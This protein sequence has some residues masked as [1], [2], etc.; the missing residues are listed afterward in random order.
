MKDF[1][2]DLDGEL[3]LLDEP[4]LGD[5]VGQAVRQGRRVRRRRAAGALAGS[6]LAVAGVVMV[7]GPLRPYTRDTVTTVVMAPD[8]PPDPR[9]ATPAA[10]PPP[11]ATPSPTPSVVMSAP[12]TD[13]AV[14]VTLLRLLPP[15]LETSGYAAQPDGLPSSYTAGAQVQVR[16]AAGPGM[17]TVF[18]ATTYSDTSCPTGFTCGTDPGGREVGIRHDAND[19]ALDTVVKS[20]HADGTVVTVEVAGCVP[21]RDGTRPERGAAP[22]SVDQAVA[23]AADPAISY[24]VPEQVKREAAAAHPS[25]PSLR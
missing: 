1:R 4:P 10:Q 3:A 13:S 7:C 16:T 2:A 5:L 12:T 8:Q 24:Q 15:G 20:R 14:L 18:V 6:V 17:V 22:L 11:S 23:L 25:L 9:S 19:C 21:G